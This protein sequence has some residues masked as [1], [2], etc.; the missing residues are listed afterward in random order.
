MG[1]LKMLEDQRVVSFE[2][3]ESKTDIHIMDECDGYFGCLLNK[4]VF[5][6]LIDELKE[7]YDEM[8]E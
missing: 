8:G 1:V 3:N 7:L 2:L 4:R 5:G 6:D